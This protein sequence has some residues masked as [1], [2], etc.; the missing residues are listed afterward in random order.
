MDADRTGTPR[1]L[2]AT[3]TNAGTLIDTAALINDGII[4]GDTA[5]SDGVEL[6]SGSVTNR[7]GGTISGL[8]G[9]FEG[10]PAPPSPL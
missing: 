10:Y 4:A 8:H 9:I 2:G 7:S 3:L 6:N 1:R 5:A